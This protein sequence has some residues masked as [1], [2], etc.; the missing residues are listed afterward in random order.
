[1]A[2]CTD[3]L[4][5]ESEAKMMSPCR[6]GIA[7]ADWPHPRARRWSFT[8]RCSAGTTP[9]FVRCL[10]LT[11]FTQPISPA[12]LHPHVTSLVLCPYLI[13]Q[14][15]EIGQSWGW[16]KMN[17]TSSREGMEALFGCSFVV[18]IVRRWT[19]CSAVPSYALYGCWSCSNWRLKSCKPRL[20]IS[21]NYIIVTCTCW[22]RKTW[23]ASKACSLQ[24]T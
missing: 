18:R 14:A 24:V 19:F 2:S 11:T 5:R 12:A 1:M 13:S 7:A 17:T 8:R 15:D 10:L 4:L 9:P 23:C 20:S 22:C 6:T 16:R 21:E 3:E